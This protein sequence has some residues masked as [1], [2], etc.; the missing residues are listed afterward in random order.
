LVAFVH[1]WWSHQNMASVRTELKVGPLE[2]QL[3]GSE[4]RAFEA[5]LQT[6]TDFAIVNSGAEMAGFNPDAG[7]KKKRRLKGLFDGIHVLT[8]PG[9]RYLRLFEWPGTVAGDE[10]F[11]AQG[12]L[13]LLI[14]EYLADFTGKIFETYANGWDDLCL[15]RGDSLVFFNCTHEDFGSVFGDQA[16]FDRLPLSSEPRPPSYT[17]YRISGEMLERDL[18]LGLTE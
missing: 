16:F 5:L 8:E 6:T 18:V 4:L 11:M 1:D 12:A 15:L 9:I 10:R 13:T 2:H 7:Q 14:R 3:N 17:E